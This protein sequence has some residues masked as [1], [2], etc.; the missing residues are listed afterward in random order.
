MQPLT[1]VYDVTRV[2]PWNCSI[3]CMGAQPKRGDAF[4]EL[5]KE[6]KLAMMD[7]L[8]EVKKSRDVRIDF[9]GGE[10]FTDMENLKVIRRAAEVLG[11]EKVGVSSSGYRVDD[12][13]A[14]ELSEMIS[15]CELTMD[16]VP[17]LEYRLRPVGYAHAA[18]HAVPHLKRH[19]IRVGIQTVL[20]NSNCN[21]EMLADIYCWLCEHGVDQWSLLRFYPSGRGANHREEILSPETEQNAVRF[22][23]ALDGSNTN[24]VKPE[25]DFHYTIRGHKKFTEEC[26][27]VKKSIG[28]LPNGDV[29]ACFWAVN[30]D[31]GVVDPRYFLGSLRTHSLP[32]ILEGAAARYWQNG[33]HLC[34]LKAA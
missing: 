26:R 7:E 11:R 24:P 31:T 6:R 22:I 9:S 10:V 1:I 4:S 30:A 12:A 34:G 14:A 8:A 3:C 21:S 19:G 5:S 2:C 27:C 28:I 25:V 13:L 32:E 16:T 20:A 17:G 29:T 18:A 15:D 23:Q 33:S